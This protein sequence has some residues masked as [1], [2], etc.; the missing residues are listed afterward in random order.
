M[1]R[2]N[3][4]TCLIKSA[5]NDERKEQHKKRRKRYNKTE[6]DSR[7]SQKKNKSKE[8]ILE[9]KKKYNMNRK[10]NNN[11]KIQKRNKSNEKQIKE[12]WGDRL[13][14]SE[15]WPSQS[16][17]KT[18]RILGQNVNGVSYFNDYLEWEMI[19][20]YMDDM[21]ID[22]MC[23]NEINLDLAKPK[24]YW[25]LSKKLKYIDKHAKLTTS[26]SKQ[27]YTDSEFKMGGTIL[28][29]RSNWSGR[30]IERG[31][32]KLGRWTFNTLTGKK[33]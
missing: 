15:K 23:F 11:R 10:I 8:R 17:E 2:K 25:E 9:I 22:I 27:S 7:E 21:Q 4:S 30:V 14:T 31:Q 29:I 20:G 32:D 33:K 16:E 24:V 12:L 28:A 6:K 26:S 19:L 1:S 3:N 18:V 13:T 5:L